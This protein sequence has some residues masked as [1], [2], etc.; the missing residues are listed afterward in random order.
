MSLDD[1][2]RVQRL[3]AAPRTDRPLGERMHRFCEALQT[4]LC[5]ALE[6]LDGAARFTHD[7]WARPGGGGGTL[8]VMEDG[9]VFARAVVEVWALDGRLPAPAAEVLGVAPQPCFASGLSLVAHAVNPYVPSILAH[10]RY[11]RLG[12]DPF[13]PADRWFGG[14]AVLVPVYPSREDA[15]AFHRAWKAVCDR[16][17]GVA[18]YRRFKGQCDDATYLPHRRQTLGVGG[19]AFDGLRDDPEGVFFFVREVGRALPSAYVPLVERR[20]ATPYGAREVAFQQLRR[21]RHAEFCLAVDRDTRLARAVAGERTLRG[22]PPAAAWP[23][24]E[25]EPGTPE[26]EAARL[27]QPHDWLGV[28]G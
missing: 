7:P 4:R 17:P 10:L 14:R 1:H 27:L 19:L 15:E 28:E 9:A 11:L 6:R 25:G 21:G 24:A 8:S 5:R 2:A 22:L 13:A 26:A 12:E 3:R 18:D 23:G 16:H 20:R